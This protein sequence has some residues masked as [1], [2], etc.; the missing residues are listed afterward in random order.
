MFH[1]IMKFI[2]DAML[3]RL[4]KR[5]RLLGFDVFYDALLSDNEVIRLSLEDDRVILTRNAALSARPLAANHLFI[6]SDFVQEQVSQVLSAFRL[7]T[8]SRPLTRCSECNEP[9][10]SIAKP[11]ARDLVPQHVYD[12]H[13]MFLRC[14]RCGRIYWEGTHV[15]RMAL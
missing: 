15:K 6:P 12:T 9:L 3:G 5:L 10:V 2:A 7:Q 11:D 8:L 4:A 13:E 14:A 1:N